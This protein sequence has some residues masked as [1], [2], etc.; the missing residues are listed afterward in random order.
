MNLNRLTEKS[1]EAIESAKAI[2]MEQKHPEN[3]STHLALALLIQED[4]L[5]V[6][7]IQRMQVSMESLVIDIE[8]LLK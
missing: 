8:K 7:I 6:Q 4:G 1:R 5:I 3:L 2:A